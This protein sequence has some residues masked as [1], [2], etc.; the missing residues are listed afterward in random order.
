M[1][2]A[3]KSKDP[4]PQDTEDDSDIV[5][6]EDEPIKELSDSNEKNSSDSS[7]K[8]EMEKTE[9]KVEVEGASSPEDG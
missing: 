4:P 3:P 7:W 8:P 2:G 5:Q 9:S 1:K 6:V